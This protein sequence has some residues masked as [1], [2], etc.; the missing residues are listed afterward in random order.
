MTF[1][2]ALWDFLT[3]L[4]RRI[5]AGWDMLLLGMAI[6]AFAFIVWPGWLWQAREAGALDERGKWQAA[7]EEAQAKHD[8][9]VAATQR[10]LDAA[11]TDLLASR[12]ATAITV[13]DLN[14]ALAA[15]RAR[16]AA[17]KARQEASGK[18]ACVPRDRAMPDSVRNQ[19]NAL[20][21][22]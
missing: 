2:A 21:H 6:V 14:A 7:K 10:K 19:L 18:G 13:N 5:A 1:L 3:A 17:E 16:Y 9:A 8:A 11:E 22:R 20:G 12:A 15:E 4:A